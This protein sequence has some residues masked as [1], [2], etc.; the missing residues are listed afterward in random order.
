MKKSLYNGGGLVTKLYPT[1]AIPWT[2]AHQA[3]PSTGFPKQEY[4][5]GLPFPSPGDLHDSGIKPESSAIAG[6]LLNCR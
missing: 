4:W 1:L 3:P 5:R 2:V 6:G